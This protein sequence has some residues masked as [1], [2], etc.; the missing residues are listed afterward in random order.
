M[1]YFVAK[2]LHLRPTEILNTWT[3][4]ELMVA[5]GYY[6]NRHSAEYIESVPEKEWAKQKPEPLTWLD[7]WAVLFVSADQMEELNSDEKESLE[8]QDFLSAASVLLG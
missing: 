8:E 6:A 1:A 5:Y 7:R 2:E 3:V 4:E